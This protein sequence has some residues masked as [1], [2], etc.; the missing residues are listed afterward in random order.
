MG[1]GNVITL[2]PFFNGSGFYHNL[3]IKNSYIVGAVGAAIDDRVFDANDDIRILTDITPSSFVNT[4]YL[5]NP[6][7][8]L[9]GDRLVSLAE[10]GALAIKSL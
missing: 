1:S 9:A 2:D 6:E 4:P 5:N 3:A 8:F 7:G 10:L